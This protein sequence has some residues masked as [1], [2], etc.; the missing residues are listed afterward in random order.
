MCTSC[1]CVDNIIKIEYNHI[2]NTS[3][4]CEKSCSVF[5]HSKIEVTENLKE[6]LTLTFENLIAKENVRYFYFG[7]FGE[8]DDLCHS[9]ITELK[10]EYPEVYRIFCLSD[11][12][13]QRLSKR[14]KWLKEEDY[15]EITYLDLNFDYWYTRI[16]Y[17]NCEII[18]NSDYCVFY[19]DE[20]VE[21]SGA[22]KALE[23]AKRKKKEIINVLQTV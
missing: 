1:E 20:T 17:R 5:G 13:H 2:V 7:G 3:L 21:Y 22:K 6:R 11:P 14:P 4:I 23:Y 10:N 18:D 16:Y 19:V 8:F 15:E 9:I 12:R